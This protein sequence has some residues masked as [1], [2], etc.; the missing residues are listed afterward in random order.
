MKLASVFEQQAGLLHQLTLRENIALPLTYHGEVSFEEIDRRTQHILELTGLVEHA[1]EYPQR[2]SRH[3]RKRGALARALILEPEIILFD[4]PLTGLDPRDAAWWM[5][6]IRQ[7]HTGEVF[8]GKPGV[9]MVITVD[10]LR[11]W[12]NLDCEFGLLNQKQFLKLGRSPEWMDSPD[13][14]IRELL[15]EQPVLGGETTFYRKKTLG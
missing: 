8:K 6:F 13:P 11:P 14:L 9:T 15:A 12:R 4:V 10:D 5:D 7:L 2:I 3:W 1:D